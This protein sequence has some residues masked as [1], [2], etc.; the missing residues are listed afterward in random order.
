MLDE[1]THA[2]ANALLQICMARKLMVA[3]RLRT[4]VFVGVGVQE[5]F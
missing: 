3:H 5:A 2:A 4:P 1:Q